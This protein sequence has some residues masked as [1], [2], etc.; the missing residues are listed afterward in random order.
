M[1][2]KLFRKKTNRTAAARNVAS[3]KG[4]R[5]F[6]V[7]NLLLTVFLWAALVVFFYSGRLLRPQQL[8]VGQ[9]APET[10]IASVD[11]RAETLAATQA[12]QRAAADTVL[13]VFTIDA[14]A[15]ESARL[16]ITTNHLT[17][18]FPSAGTTDVQTIIFT[19]LSNTV[20]GGIIS[21]GGRKPDLKV[22]PL[23]ER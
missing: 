7:F 21:A 12:K 5:H 8:V 15:L 17:N 3:R 10:I 13:P 6:S 14:S 22:S 20:C 18:L 11:F 4:S 1:K 2:Q 9:Q 23:P 16:V 19:A